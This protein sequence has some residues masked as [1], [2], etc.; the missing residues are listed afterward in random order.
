[1]HNKNN[2]FK[3]SL[4]D[5]HKHVWLASPDGHDF[6]SKV[7]VTWLASHK[8]SKETEGLMYFH[9]SAVGT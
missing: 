8:N 5:A 4:G 7:R 1:M 2:Y 3:P 6:C 9:Q